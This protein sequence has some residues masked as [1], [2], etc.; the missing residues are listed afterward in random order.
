MHL[1]NGWH[2]RLILAV[3]LLGLLAIAAPAGAANAVKLSG[4]TT[5]LKLDS[6]TAKALKK[7]GV[8]IAPVKPATSAA[9]GLAFP[10][11]GG[12]IDPQTAV[13]TITHKG[14]FTLS[15][16]K[17]KL[18]L[19]NP[20]LATGKKPTLSVQLGKAK[21]VIG[22]LGLGKARVTRAGFATNVAGV[23]VSLTP[24][25]AKA[26]NAAFGVTA[27]KGGLV[28]GTAS[29]KSTPAQIALASGTAMLA[30][31]PTTAGALKQL[32]VTLAPAAGST[33]TATG[34]LT[35]K[36]T[37]G[38]VDVKTLAGKIQSSGGLALSR[39]GQTLALTSPLITLSKTPTL[40]I[41]Y[42]GAPIAIADLDVSRLTTNVNAKTRTITLGGAVAKLNGV[43]ASTLNGLFGVTQ[44][45]A[46]LTVGTA[47]LVA[48]AR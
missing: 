33:A 16:G 11:S 12:S 17:T 5:T 21:L 14:G 28:L 46:G 15:A 7:L 1:R 42:S 38:L 19:K 44:I 47:S 2:G 41:D 35:F 37:G 4:G 30:I 24:G 3:A 13:G 29:V 6:G 31:D 45:Q 25:A 8:K 39:G 10:I 9:G 43:A 20:T 23:K 32:G 40:G 26:L 34:A 18:T 22:T 36:V 48:Q 27:F